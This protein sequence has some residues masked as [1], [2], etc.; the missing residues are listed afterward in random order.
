[1]GVWELLLLSFNKHTAITWPHARERWAKR[2]SPTTMLSAARRWKSQTE[3]LQDLGQLLHLEVNA[4]LNNGTMKYLSK[5]MLC[6]SQS[7]AL[8]PCLSSPHRIWSWHQEH[9]SPVEHNIVFALTART[10]I[11]Q[12][13][14]TLS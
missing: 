4:K 8:A 3:A 14:D 1:M 5:A 9:S 7:P 10:C 6:G 2:V 11:I 12:L 13:L